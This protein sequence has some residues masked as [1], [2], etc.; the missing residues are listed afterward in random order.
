MSDDL[1]S[2]SEKCP[3]AA[4]MLRDLMTADRLETVD[5]PL[6]DKSLCDVIFKKARAGCDVWRN[7]AE[8]RWPKRQ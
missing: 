7:A 3:M 8:S 6:I 4:R 2:F 5:W 1:K